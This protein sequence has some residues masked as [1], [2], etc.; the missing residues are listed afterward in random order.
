MNSKRAL[1]IKNTQR[2][3]HPKSFLPKLV[4]E[5]LPIGRGIRSPW[6][7][8]RLTRIQGSVSQAQQY[9]SETVKNHRSVLSIR[10]PGTVFAISELENPGFLKDRNYSA[11]EK[12]ARACPSA[13]GAL[14]MTTQ[15]FFQCCQNVGN[16]CSAV[17]QRHQSARYGLSGWPWCRQSAQSECSRLADCPGAAT[18]QCCQ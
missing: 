5:P 13:G 18:P 16:G 7:G 3:E 12:T 9:L 1:K 14:E 17:L 8:H 10:K 4:L 2:K 15:T 11:L 6:S